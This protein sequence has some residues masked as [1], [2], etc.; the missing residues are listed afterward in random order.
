MARTPRPGVAPATGSPRTRCG[1]GRPGRRLAAQRARGVR[2]DAGRGVH[3]RSLLVHLTGLRDRRG[4]GPVRPDPT[5]G[6][7]RH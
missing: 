4:L 3:R 1:T 7:I 6:P 2:R 5:S